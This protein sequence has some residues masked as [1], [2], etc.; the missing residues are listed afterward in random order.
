MAQGYAHQVDVNWSTRQSRSP[1]VVQV[2]LFAQHSG[3]LSKSWVGCLVYTTCR[4]VGEDVCETVLS[5]VFSSGQGSDEVS[6]H[7]H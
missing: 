6:D 4:H 3:R 1:R 2:R 5:P 7:E